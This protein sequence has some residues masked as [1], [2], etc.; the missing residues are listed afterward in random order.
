MILGHSL[1]VHMVSDQSI[2]AP[3]KSNLKQTVFKIK[4]WLFLLSATWNPT[5]CS[6]HKTPVGHSPV[7]IENALKP[8]QAG[9]RRT[10]LDAVVS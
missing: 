8:R 3:L 2:P 7:E 10:E 1:F 9:S 5:L 4:T 6:M